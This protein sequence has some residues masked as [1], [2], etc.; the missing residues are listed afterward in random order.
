[1][2]NPLDLSKKTFGTKTASKPEVG[3]IFP[4]CCRDIVNNYNSDY[5]CVPCARRTRR[6][7]AASIIV[8]R[9]DQGKQVAAH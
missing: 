8:R 3:M 4:A 6:L 9:K 7:P 2:S 5:A 1:M